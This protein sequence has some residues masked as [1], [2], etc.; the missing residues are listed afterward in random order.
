MR[1]SRL[2]AVASACLVA[3][4]PTAAHAADP[5]DY[6]ALGDSFTAG[7]LIPGQTWDV[8]G[9]LRSDRNYPSLLARETGARLTD[10]SCSGATTHGFWSPQS[11]FWGTNA[12]QLDAIGPGTDLVTIGISGNDVGF[13]DVLLTCLS[14]GLVDP[15]GD[16]C[17][18]HYVKDGKDELRTRIGDVAED[19]AAALDAVHERAPGARVL[20]V[21]YPAL[22]PA[23]GGCWWRATLGKGDV[24][25]LDGVNRAL[26]DMLGRVAGEHGAEF[27]DVWE[28]GHDICAPGA[29][30]WV[31]AVIPT[32]P[33]APV[34]PN[35]SGMAAVA[36]RIAE[37]L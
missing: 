2:L 26:N 22:L 28:R 21:G 33:A 20:L 8:P 29:E 10:V 12:P 23:S 16:P 15:W 37:A 13:M 35:A 1:L 34:H 36:E 4:V 17:R 30:R 27:V 14:K 31:E 9:C 11:T 19:V 6:V 18:R 25:Y 7:P 32:R 5:V 3:L 24:P